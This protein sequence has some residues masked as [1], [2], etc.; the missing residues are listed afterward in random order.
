MWGN[1][2]WC[3][4]LEVWFWFK[5][6]KFGETFYETICGDFDFEILAKI[7]FEKTKSLVWNWLLMLIVWDW[8]L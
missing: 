5:V 2:I 6:L 7:D 3:F 1:G 8:L 4:S